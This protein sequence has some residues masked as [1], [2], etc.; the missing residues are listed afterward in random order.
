VDLVATGPAQA[1]LYPAN[2][3]YEGLMTATF[4]NNGAGTYAFG[5]V[6]VTLPAGATFDFQGIPMAQWGMNGCSIQTD[7]MWE[8]VADPSVIPARGG[9][10][11]VKFHIIVNIAPQAQQMT[12]EGGQ[13]QPVAFAANGQRKEAPDA[14]PADNVH[15]FTLVLNPS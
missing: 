4:R 14:N 3:R 5:T 6:R 9:Q 13:I 15:R 7:Q 2:G 8:C 1:I 12:L 10:A 11:T